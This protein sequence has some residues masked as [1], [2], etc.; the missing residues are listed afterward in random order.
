M[1][2]QQAIKHSE[3]MVKCIR[4]FLFLTE[5]AMPSVNSEFF[6]SLMRV[7]GVIEGR[8]EERFHQNGTLVLEDMKDIMYQVQKSILSKDTKGSFD[9]EMR[10]FLARA[11]GCLEQAFDIVI[12]DR[13]MP[14]RPSGFSDGPGHRI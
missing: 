4:A 6:K 9:Q 7:R 8:I 12:N 13:P 14:P 1:S 5:D 3:Q 2:A 10:V 11:S